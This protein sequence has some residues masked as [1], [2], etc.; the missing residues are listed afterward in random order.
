MHDVLS[1]ERLGISTAA[2]L[3]DTFKAQAVYQGSQ[4]GA[5]EQAL[6]QILV[7]VK[8]PIS[9]RTIS[10]MRAKADACFSEVVQALSVERKMKVS[11]ASLISE[12]KKAKPC[13]T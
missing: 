11:A 7:W 9:D 13:K 5:S 1:F 6:G 3:S 2:L 4:I 12:A 10:E 8:H